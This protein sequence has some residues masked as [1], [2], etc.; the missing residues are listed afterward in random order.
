M[1]FLGA[2]VAAAVAAAAAAA[3]AATAGTHSF[4]TKRMNKFWNT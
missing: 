3:V 1:K 2:A 4:T